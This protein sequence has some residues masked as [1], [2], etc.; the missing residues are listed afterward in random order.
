MEAFENLDAL[1]NQNQIE[2]LSDF[3]A[4]KIDNAVSDTPIKNEPVFKLGKISRS[5]WRELGM[6]ARSEIVKRTRNGIDINLQ[7]FHEY[8]AAT[9]E[10]KSGIMQTRGLGS[11]VVTLH[12]IS[13]ERTLDTN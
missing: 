7:P 9:K 10:Y 1:D 11:S 12:D 6:S 2:K 5:E 4:L 8:S 13:L 3:S